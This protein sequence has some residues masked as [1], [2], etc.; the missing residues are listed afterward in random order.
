MIRAY[1]RHLVD[2]VKK[3]L[4]KRL[5]KRI[6][7][8]ERTET[9]HL[10]IACELP[11]VITEGTLTDHKGDVTLLK[12]KPKTRFPPKIPLNILKNPAKMGAKQ[13]HKLTSIGRC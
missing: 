7:K 5:S 12:S 3:S 8:L 2:H 6:T 4:K 1:V 11:Q 10:C 9:G 13:G